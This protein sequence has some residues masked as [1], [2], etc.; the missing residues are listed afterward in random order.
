MG[1]TSVVTLLGLGLSIDYGL[2]M[3]SRFR[4]ELHAMT[5][6]DAGRRPQV[7]RAQASAAL[8]TTLST[9][10]RTVAYSALTVAASV[11]GLM[12]FEM[13]MLRAFGVG[14][15]VAVLAPLLTAITLVPAL[16][17]IFAR[18]LAR[19]SLFAR[20]RQPRQARLARQARPTGSEEKGFLAGLVRGVQKH[21][22]VVAIAVVAI[23]VGFASP[24]TGAKVRVAGMEALPDDGPQAAFLADTD[25]NYPAFATPDITVVSRG[26][27]AQT[28]GLAETIAALPN[29]TGAV[30]L[31]GD[32]YQEVAV[33]TSS[34]DPQGDIVND[35]VTAVRD[36][37]PGFEILVTGEAA[38]TMDFHQ[39]MKEGLPLAFG[40]V[41]IAT[42][43]LLFLMTGSVVIPLSAL[44]TNAISLAAAM[45]VLTWIFQEGNLADLLGVTPMD[46]VYSYVLLM[47]AMFGFGLSMDYEVFLISRMKEARDQG[48]SNSQ[49]VR[50]GLTRSG[51][52]ITSAAVVIVAVFAGFATGETIDIKALGIGL[53]VAVT[54][55]A[56]LV[57][58]LLV[59]ATMTILGRWNWWAPRPLRA[60]YRRFGVTH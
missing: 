29:V 25:A 2:L 27:A 26:D 11:A 36:L 43:V 9:A 56:T 6:P 50:R 8:E 60:L 17:V 48:A 22:W 3:V 32:G 58:L 5:G 53:A 23:L 59:P 54:L 16:L 12:L 39:T 19:P 45:G 13:P 34:S 7:T 47:M 21:P 24:L 42:F 55:D 49:A 31:P 10:G 14:G 15:F 52:I 46:G 28:A 33:T 30:A 40:V 18:R 4:E 51:R 41:V 20:R 35:A 44:V 57:R 1:L 38:S 37:D